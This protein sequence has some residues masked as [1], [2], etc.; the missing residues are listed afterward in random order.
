MA[1]N[2]L[3]TADYELLSHMWQNK[4]KIIFSFGKILK[5]RLSLKL[6]NNNVFKINFSSVILILR[7]NK[8]CTFYFFIEIFYFV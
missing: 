5:R 4:S 3:T 6:E 8:I 2:C 7:N 1:L